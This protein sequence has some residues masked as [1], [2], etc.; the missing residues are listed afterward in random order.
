MLPQDIPDGPWQELAADYFIYK[1]KEYLLIAD[2]FSKYPFIYKVHSKTSD[3]VTHHLQ[4]L[5]LQYGTPW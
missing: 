4:D 1:G 2:T 3:S 5:F